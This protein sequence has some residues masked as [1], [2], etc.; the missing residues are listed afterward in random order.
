MPLS[1]TQAIER[2]IAPLRRHKWAQAMCRCGCSCCPISSNIQALVMPENAWM[3]TLRLR[4]SLWLP[5]KSMLAIAFNGKF[6][7]IY[8][9]T[10]HIY[11]KMRT[12]PAQ[13]G[14]WVLRQY[15]NIAKYSIVPLYVLF[16]TNIVNNETES[17]S[18]LF[19]STPISACYYERATIITSRHP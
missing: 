16:S 5:G 2:S 19:P 11:P 13:T 17:S 14:T 18:H 15:W 9:N 1:G 12:R 7:Q 4:N 6:V 8:A 3:P 10:H